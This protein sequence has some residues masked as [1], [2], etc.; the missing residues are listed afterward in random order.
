MEPLSSIPDTEEIVRFAVGLSFNVLGFQ[1]NIPLIMRLVELVGDDNKRERYQD[2]D[3]YPVTAETPYRP[4][5]PPF[6]SQAAVAVRFELLRSYY[7]EELSAIATCNLFYALN[8]THEL[9]WILKQATRSSPFWR[10]S[11]VLLY[12]LNPYSRFQ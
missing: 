11:E 5:A 9:G 1:Q 2:E 6:I 10:P 8:R 7:G 4:P 12:Y 3:S